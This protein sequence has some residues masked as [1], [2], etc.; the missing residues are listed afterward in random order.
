MNK[1][2]NFQIGNFEY[3]AGQEFY[4]KSMKTFIFVDSSEVNPEEPPMTAD[5]KTWRKY[6]R[7]V[8]ALQKKI[9]K[10]A[11][12]DAEKYTWSRTAGCSCGCSPAFTSKDEFCITMFGK[13]T[14]YK[15][16]WITAKK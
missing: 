6:N 11:G 8:V 10:D 1:R 3:I 13:A 4:G 2:Y 9:L 15:I 12:I 7:E 5:D 14:P 16:L